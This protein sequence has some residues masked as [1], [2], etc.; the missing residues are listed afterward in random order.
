M[1]E[2]T[3]ERLLIRQWKDSDYEPFAAMNAD[4]AV[5]EHFPALLTRAASDEIVDRLKSAI[6]RRGFGFWAVEIVQTGRFIGFAGLSVPGPEAPFRPGVEIGWRLA[7][8]AWGHGYATEAAR[9]ALAYAFGRAG[10][11]EVMSFTTTTNK[12]SQRVMERIGMTHNETDDFD[13]PRLPIGHPLRRHVLYR[14]TH[15]QWQA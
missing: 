2:L 12:R 1:T 14:I 7:K 13:D 4:P 8:Q 6:D 3:T 11:D 9:A 10:L 5:M 15:A